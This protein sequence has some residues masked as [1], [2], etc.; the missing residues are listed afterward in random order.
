MKRNMKIILSVSIT[1]L[2]LFSGV[3]GYFIQN[4]AKKIDNLEITL[5]RSLDK[6]DEEYSTNLDANDRILDTRIDDI[7]MTLDRYSESTA[8]QI[9]ETQNT[10]SDNLLLTNNFKNIV[11]KTAISISDSVLPSQSVYEKA[12]QSI[13]RI[14][15][16][17]YLL[18]S[19]F[20][21][22]YNDFTN[23]KSVLP[24]IITAYH[25]IEFI[26]KGFFHT[27]ENNTVLIT[28]SDGR[29]CRGDIV[30]CSKELDI[31]VLAIHPLQMGKPWVVADLLPLSSLIVA[32]SSKVNTGDPVF[33]IGSPDDGETN[34]QGLKESISAGI[35]S[36]VNR[37]ATIQY[38]I[39]PN[40]LQL[41]A[42]VNF[43]NSGG[44]LLD[45]D[46]EVI[47]MVIARINPIIGEGI[48]Y[49]V[50]S[51]QLKQVISLLSESWGGKMIGV[52][53][54]K[55]EYPQTGITVKDITPKEIVEYKN[56]ITSGAE[57]TAVA[58]LA[59][60]A[61]VVPG[62]IIIS[63]DDRPVRNSDEFYSF[64]VE[65]YSRGDTINLKL[66][67]NGEQV[68]VSLKVL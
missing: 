14:S 62:D 20:L 29:I 47:G 34:R 25:V 46:G 12:K 22:H 4:L 26:T 63:L 40:L 13:V 42:A 8:R 54:F 59:G 7:Q 43:G 60:S 50:S 32:D 44:P 58:G 28:L 57:V 61:G 56:T 9:A 52:P 24:C 6:M 53:A 35:I 41:D 55:Y 18:G 19:G 65:Y 2:I 37:S 21:V 23:H 10:L 31:A 11:S 16:K 5:D 15:Y 39:V 67:R 64:I 3:S 30:A 33:V 45:V 49:A 51:N 68:S 38:N 27:I 48:G 1:L 17:G 36:Q 66:W